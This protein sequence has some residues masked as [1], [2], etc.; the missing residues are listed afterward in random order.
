MAFQKNHIPSSKSCHQHHPNP[1]HQYRWLFPSNADNKFYDDDDDDDD[2]DDMDD[3]LLTGWSRTT[4]TRF[5]TSL[6]KAIPGGDP[7]S[8]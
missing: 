7:R 4:S 6:E 8:A 2:D 1:E 5:T 3:A